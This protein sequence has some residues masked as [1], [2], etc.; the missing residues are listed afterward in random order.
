KDVDGRADIYALGGML[1]VMLTGK[2]PHDG[3]TLVKLLEQKEKGRFE[4]A[5]KLNPNVPDKLDLIIDKMLTKSLTARYQ[6]CSELIQ[7]LQSLGLANDY[8]TLLFPEGAPAGMV[9]KTSSGGRSSV[10]A[11]PSAVSSITKAPPKENDPAA[12]DI[13]Y[14]AA[15]TTADG[16]KKV[17]K[18]TQ[19]QMKELIKSKQLDSTDEASRQAGTGYRALATYKEFELL[20]RAQV[21][22]KKLEKK[23]E[24]LA[25]KFQ[26]I[27]QEV[28]SYERKKWWSRFLHN[29]GGWVFFLIG[30]GIL[31][32]I[33][34]AIWYFFPELMNLF[35]KKV[36]AA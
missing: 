10:T 3:E 22:Q 18:L 1:Y 30:M 29:L 5:R 11:L 12:G 25:D 19:A 31:V 17:R 16:K 28:D 4:P 20:F 21:A 9:T 33:A 8:L 6:T 7:D 27:A 23:S 15:G 35:A 36:G 13:W 14:V 24:K 34:L 26:Q 2:K 32:V